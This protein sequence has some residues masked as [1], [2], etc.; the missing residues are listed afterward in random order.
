MINMEVSTFF[1]IK[2]LF[3]QA[4]K[5]KKYAP[6]DRFIISNLHLTFTSRPTNICF[7]NIKYILGIFAELDIIYYFSI[8]KVNDLL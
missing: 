8:A 4:D 5:H 6:H 2:F 3:F 1:L 7:I